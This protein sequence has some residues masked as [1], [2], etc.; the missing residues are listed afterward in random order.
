MDRNSPA[1]PNNIYTPG[2]REGFTKLEYAILK[3]LA[4]QATAHTAAGG[5]ASNAA[6]ATAVASLTGEAFGGENG[7]QPASPCAIHTS[8]LALGLTK[9]EYAAIEVCAAYMRAN[10]T[11]GVISDTAGVVTE[12]ASVSRLLFPDEDNRNRPAFP[13]VYKTET[14]QKGLTKYEYSVSVLTAAVSASNTTLVSSIT[15][16]T[17]VSN[18]R[19]EAA[20]VFNGI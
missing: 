2:S 16:A 12:A 9:Y 20:A 8:D 7:S 4:A 14:G 10:I 15:D 17:M 5:I 11:T 13:T 6:L 1:R 19:S 18:A 3:S